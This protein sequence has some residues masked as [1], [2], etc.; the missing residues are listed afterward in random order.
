MTQGNEATLIAS[1]RRSDSTGF[2]TG[3][4]KGLPDHIRRAGQTKQAG[5][6]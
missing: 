1:K 5:I 3:A 4:M 6:G 2:L